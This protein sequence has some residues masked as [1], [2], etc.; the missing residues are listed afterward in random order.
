MREITF[1]TETTG[2]DPNSGHRIIEIGCVELIDKVKTGQFFHTYITYLPAFSINATR[3]S[4]AI[5]GIGIILS[6][7]GFVRK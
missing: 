4:F 3:A 5:E 1:D 7:L 2:I 6:Y